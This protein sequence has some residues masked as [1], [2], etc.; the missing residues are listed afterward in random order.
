VI[1][2][3]FLIFAAISVAAALAFAG[4]ELLIELIFRK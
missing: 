1:V 4:L 3:T 2:V